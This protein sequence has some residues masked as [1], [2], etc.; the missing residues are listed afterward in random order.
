MLGIATW[1]AI[2]GIVCDCWAEGKVNT[3]GGLQPL[4]EHVP[5][6]LEGMLEQYK[7]V[8]GGNGHTSTATAMRGQQAAQMCPSLPQVRTSS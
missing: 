1:A 8:D 3:A 4:T 5:K 7:V 2:F 6:E